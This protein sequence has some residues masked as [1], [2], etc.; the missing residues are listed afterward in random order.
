MS[1]TYELYHWHNGMWWGAGQRTEEQINALRKVANW[2]TQYDGF[3]SIYLPKL[4]KNEPWWKVVE[5]K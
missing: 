1:K 3:E 2:T 4:F 5:V